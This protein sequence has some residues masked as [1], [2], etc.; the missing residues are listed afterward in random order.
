VATSEPVKRTSTSLLTK[1]ETLKQTT[2]APLQ[3]AFLIKLE[4]VRPHE[5]SSFLAKLTTRTCPEN[6][7][8]CSIQA[9]INV[10]NKYHN[11][12]LHEI[13]KLFGES[14]QLTKWLAEAIANYAMII[15]ILKFLKSFVLS[16]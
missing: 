12:K 13:T 11:A 9:E 5:M 8:L 6:D 16:I 4:K 15:S 3:S 1:H 10:S 2:T 7:V 14:R